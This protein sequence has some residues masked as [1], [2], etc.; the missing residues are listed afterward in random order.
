MTTPAKPTFRRP[1]GSSATLGDGMVNVMTGVGTRAD[2]VT[3][4]RYG[5]SF[6][7]QYQVEA[8]YRTSGL[9][10]KIHDIIPDEETREGRNWQA[11]PDEIEKLEAVERRFDVWGKLKEARL[12]A[13]LHGGSVIIMGLGGLSETPAPTRSELRYLLVLSRH[14]VRVGELDTN[15]NSPGFGVPMYFEITSAGQSA[16]IHPSRVITFIGQKVPSGAMAYGNDGFWG[17]PLLM[18]IEAAMKNVDS[19]QA[20]VATLL[21][22]AKVD[23]LTIPGLTSMV[24]TAEGE[25]LL[26]RRLQVA[27][28][29]QSILNTR[30][31]DGGQSG[32]EAEKWETRQLA[33]S[34]LPDV[35]RS[36]QVFLAG[37]VDIPYTRLFGESPGGLNADGDGQQTDFNKKIQ[38][39]QKNEL[40]PRI[41]RLDDYLIPTALGSRPPSIYWTFAPLQDADPAQESE[42]EKRY[43][44]SVKIYSETG[45][46]PDVV[47]AKM[48]RGRLMESGAWPGVEGAYEEADAAGEVAPIE[49]E[50]PEVDTE[51]VVPLAVA[52]NDALPRPLYVQRKLLNSDEFIRWAKAQGF[53]SVTSPDELHVTVTFS[54]QAV[55]WMKMGENWS[56]DANGNL[57]VNPGGARIVEPLGDKGAVVLLFTSSDLSRRNKQM[58]DL[59]ASWDYEDYQPHV[60]ITYD[61]ADVDL[62]E[63]EPYRGKLVFGPEIF[64][65]LTDDWRP[66]EA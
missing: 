55:D 28:Q 21:S 56:S 17:D 15:V 23:T 52:A 54:R 13:R 59:G 4:A 40:R 65:E 58:R 49:E 63:V 9:C 62:D 47:L 32:Q 22:E 31:I 6:V 48:T 8:A 34:G 19:S 10:R 12:L 33:F 2:R 20:N 44:E 38:S 24:A 51:N 30:M 35:L 18:S 7:D 42:I 66:T 61:G 5:L 41:E 29:L 50:D 46:V 14:Q 16:K 64:E 27:Q 60:T 36:F 37:V 45:A 57:T 25:S 1:A 26:T 3:A 11:K 39:G 53:K 43:A